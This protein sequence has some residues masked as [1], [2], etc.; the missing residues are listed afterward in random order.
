MSSEPPRASTRSVSP[1]NDQL[2]VSA[3]TGLTNALARVQ[4]TVAKVNVVWGG[5]E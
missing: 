2:I 5:G 1:T 3:H 4:A